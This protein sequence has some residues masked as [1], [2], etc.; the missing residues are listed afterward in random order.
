MAIEKQKKIWIIS[1][2]HFNHSAIVNDFE[3]RHQDYDKKIIK[4]INNTVWVD[5]ILIH[6]WDVI[7]NTQPPLKFY[8]SQIKC[9]TIVLVKWNHDTKSNTFYYNSWFTFVCD[10]IQL[11]NVVFSH[12]PIKSISNWLINIHW[13]L[14]EWHRDILGYTNNPERYFLYN[15]KGLNYQP[16]LLSNIIKKFK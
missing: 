15:A 9:K 1:D 13:H 16:L 8:L 6:L 12:I 10:K 4:A 3:F 2:T 14:H 11:N 7:F 5:D